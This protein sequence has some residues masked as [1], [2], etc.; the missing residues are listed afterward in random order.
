M[1]D[2]IFQPIESHPDTVTYSFEWN[3]M[4]IIAPLPPLNEE[5]PYKIIIH[6]NAWYHELL[7][8]GALSYRSGEVIVNRKTS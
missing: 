8:S 7:A 4:R 1:T 6:D 2:P 5:V 3:G